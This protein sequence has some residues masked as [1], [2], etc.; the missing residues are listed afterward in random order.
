M[1]S[2]RGFD[3]NLLK[4]ETLMAGRR[5]VGFYDQDNI[6]QQHRGGNSVPF[7]KQGWGGEGGGW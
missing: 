1:P 7:R 6:S 2:G 3:A 4:A 5:D